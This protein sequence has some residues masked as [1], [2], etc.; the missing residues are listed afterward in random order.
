M[1]AAMHIFLTTDRLVLRQFTMTD[2]DNAVELDSD[3]DVM[4]YLNG[5]RPT[6]RDEIHTRYLP[7]WMSYYTRYTGYGFWAAEADGEFIGCVNLRPPIGA[8][9]D[10]PELGYRLRKSAWGNGYATEISR[11]LIDK[12]FTDCGAQ[13]VFAD[14]LAVNKGSRRVLEKAGLT[15]VGT[16]CEDEPHHIPGQELGEVVY[17]ITRG[18]WQTT[19]SSRERQCTSS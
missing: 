14:T 17:A 2:E 11:A 5:G 1:G 13:R 6:P 4:R 9:P 16:F 10:E 12:A 8:S 7:A 18:E 19:R 3:P 15:L